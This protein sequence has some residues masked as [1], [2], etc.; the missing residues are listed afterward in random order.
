[1]CVQHTDDILNS[2]NCSN[3]FTLQTKIFHFHTSY[4]NKFLIDVKQS[5]NGSS[6][7][8]ATNTQ[9]YLLNFQII[10]LEQFQITPFNKR[11]S[12]IYQII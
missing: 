1:M 11:L 8:P 2:H 3:S 12:A 6:N 5:V 4:C 9:A 7:F 10:D